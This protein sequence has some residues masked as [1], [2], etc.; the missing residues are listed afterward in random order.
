MPSESKPCWLVIRYMYEIGHPL[1]WQPIAVYDNKQQ[2]QNESELLG[3]VKGPDGI[4][5]PIGRIEKLPLTL[6]EK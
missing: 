1:A 6:G 4:S 5:R 2:A 3:E